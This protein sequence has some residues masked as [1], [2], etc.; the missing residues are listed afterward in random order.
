MTD[1]Q[2]NIHKQYLA[3][4]DGPVGKAVLADIYREGGL[5]RSTFNIDPMKAAY[6]E[7][8][9]DLALYIFNKLDTQ[10]ADRMLAERGDK[11]NV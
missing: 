7:G 1:E 2:M 9:R 8:L 4:F 3:V 6:K 11:S 5:M 10:R